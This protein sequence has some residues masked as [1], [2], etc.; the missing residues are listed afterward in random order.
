MTRQSRAPTILLTRPLAQS[1]RFA[2]VLADVISVPV[3]ISPLMATEFLLPALPHHTYSAVLLTSETGAIAAGRMRE[4]LPKRAWCVGDRTAQV[5]TE[6]AI[7][8]PQDF[9]S[10]SILE[11]RAR[12]DAAIDLL[13]KAKIPVVIPKGAKVG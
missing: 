8:G 6:A 2:A 10:E 1:Q 11:Y 13:Q 5:A 4:H 12:R 9:V 7:R 3:M